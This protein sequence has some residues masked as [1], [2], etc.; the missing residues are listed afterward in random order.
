MSNWNFLVI[1][2]SAL[3]FK[4]LQ[5][6]NLVLTSEL[7]RSTTLN[8]Q[9]LILISLVF[10]SL[11]MYSIA[12]ASFCPRDWDFLYFIRLSNFYRVQNYFSG[13]N[14]IAWLS[15]FAGSGVPTH[16]RT[17]YAA[18]IMVIYVISFIV[19]QQPQV[20]Q[21]TSQSQLPVLVSLIVFIC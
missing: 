18:R 2:L 13:K 1:F 21:T 6:C 16:K 11:H 12:N 3:V 17:S 19:V 5:L 4:S 7:I 8:R 14:S 20:F 10:L 9:A 15:T